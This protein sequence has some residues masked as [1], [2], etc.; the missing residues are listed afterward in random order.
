MM[1]TS[2]TSLIH[3][4]GS[5]PVI[6]A[7]V[8]LQIE[9]SVSFSTAYSP[10]SFLQGKLPS[11]RTQQSTRSRSLL[12]SIVKLR[13]ED[14]EDFPD[15]HALMEYLDGPSDEFEFAGGFLSFEEYQ[16]MQLKQQ[17][18]GNC[19]LFHACSANDLSRIAG[20]MVLQEVAPG[21]KLFAQGESGEA[22][23]FLKSGSLQAIG[24]KPPVNGEKESESVIYT[25][26][27]KPG[28]F[29]GELALLFGQPRAASIVG[30]SA[31][32]TMV[33]RLDKAAFLQAVVDSPVYETAKRLILAKY[34]SKRIIDVLPEIRVDEIIGLIKARLSTPRN[35]IS[36]WL[37]TWRTYSLGACVALICVKFVKV[38]ALKPMLF[39][40]VGVL[41]HLL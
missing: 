26:Y 35:Q 15:P 21:E 22:M 25:T 12:T 13:L 9:P 6:T 18:L 23:Y 19:P 36:D 1:E 39:L 8:G 29:F 5:L 24:E 33:Y 27:S 2:R 40:A 37:S 34:K 20:C 38:A 41:A 16:E 4:L 32:P 31:E 10:S 7:L 28:N 14:D 3:L 11:P 17:Y 30:S